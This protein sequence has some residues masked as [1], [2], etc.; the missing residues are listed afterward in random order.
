MNIQAVLGSRSQPIYSQI[1]LLTV[2]RDIRFR[3]KVATLQAKDPMFVRLIFF[4]FDDMSY[5]LEYLTGA[6]KPVSTNLA[7]T[8][9]TYSAF[10]FELNT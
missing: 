5:R 2:I 8:C 3:E 1:G 10:I 7:S 9:E 6:N 4:H